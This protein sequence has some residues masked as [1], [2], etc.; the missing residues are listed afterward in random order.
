MH[1]EVEAASLSAPRRLE[2]A[3]A[4]LALRRARGRFLAAIHLAD[5]AWDILLDL[6]VAERTRR[7][8]SISSLCVAAAVPQTTALRWIK[9]LTEQG[10]LHRSDDDTDRRR[11]NVALSAEAVV[12][13]EACLDTGLGFL[14]P[15]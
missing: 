3:R 14:A 7:P 5:P 1:Q 2:L 12:A 10:L 15:L 6:Y 13:M 11:V 8:V 4:I 9:L